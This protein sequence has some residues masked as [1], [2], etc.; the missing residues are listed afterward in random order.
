MVQVELYFW[1]DDASSTVDFYSPRNEVVAL[2]SILRLVENSLDGC[3]EMQKNILQELRNAI[4]YMIANCSDK[5]SVKS[6]IVEDNCCDKENCLLQ[7]GE[8]NGMRSRLRI[9]CT[10]FLS[11]ILFI[12]F[13]FFL[14]LY[15]L[16]V[17]QA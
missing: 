14:L 4:L 6:V 5:N 13:S 7:W 2:N 10:Y 16:F 11:L 9:A 3:T 8:D 17:N 1:E 12:Y 15:N